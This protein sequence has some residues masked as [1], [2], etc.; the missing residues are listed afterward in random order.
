[1][2]LKP[3][4]I[5]RA[6]QKIGMVIKDGGDRFAKFYVDGKLILWTKRSMGSGKLDGNIPHLIRQQMKLDEEQFARLI[7]CPLKRPEYI[8]ILKEKGLI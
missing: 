6:W 5:D 2:S 8:E 4:E 1:M 3:K 7:A